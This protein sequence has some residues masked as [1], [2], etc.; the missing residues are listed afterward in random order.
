M[1]TAN[2]S[3]LIFRRFVHGPGSA[4]VRTHLIIHE[5]VW[6]CL[7]S[8]SLKCFQPKADIVSWPAKTLR[9]NLCSSALAC[10]HNSAI[11]AYSRSYVRTQHMCAPHVKLI[12]LSSIVNLSMCVHKAQFHIHTYKP[13]HSCTQTHHKYF[14]CATTLFCRK[15]NARFVQYTKFPNINM[16]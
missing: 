7:D 11:S 1:G 5:L 12:Y 14:C 10:I 6:H 3:L 9:F 13:T 16:A 15:S 2:L 4:S 8:L